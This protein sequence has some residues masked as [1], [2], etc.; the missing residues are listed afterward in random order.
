[1]LSCV[2]FQLPLDFTAYPELCAEGGKLAG[3]EQ[4]YKS[5]LFLQMFILSFFVPSPSLFS[6]HRLCHGT[7][8]GTKYA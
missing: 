1:M 4:C 7:P 8:S 3:F 2:G 5:P 6:Y